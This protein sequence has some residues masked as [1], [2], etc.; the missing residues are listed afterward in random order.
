MDSWIVGEGIRLTMNAVMM[1]RGLCGRALG[2]L[3]LMGWL[4]GCACGPCGGDDGCP[5]GASLKGDA[6]PDGTEQWCEMDDGKK[7]GPYAR[8]HDSG[9]KAEA[10]DYKNGQKAGPWKAWYEDGQL[11]WEAEFY[12]DVRDGP[13]TSYFKDGTKRSEGFYEDD[14]MDGRWQ[15]YHK[16]GK[17][18]EEGDYSAGK[19]EGRWTYFTDR[20]RKDK[21]ISYKDGVQ[22]KVKQF[23]AEGKAVGEPGQV[24]NV[25]AEAVGRADDRC[26]DGG[27]M[28]GQEPPGGTKIWCEKDGKKHGLERQW[29]ESGK[30]WI[31]GE[32]TNG[33]KDGEWVEFYENGFAT[34]KGKYVAGK[35]DGPWVYNYF[36]GSPRTKGSYAMGKKTGT[37]ITYHEDGRQKGSEDF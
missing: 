28:L 20:G 5:E 31:E 25:P 12:D 23:N 14:K 15:V 4:A 35:Q 32:Y 9:Q 11:N 13:Y 30:R 33:K 2:V 17:V 1:R 26:K 19:K 27:Q 10:G 6:P 22:K 3:V 21:A 36:N 34:S 8:Y 16:T 37:W 7:H 24:V 18:A 29:W